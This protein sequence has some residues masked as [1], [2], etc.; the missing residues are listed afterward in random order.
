[1]T[2]AIADQR[3]TIRLPPH[4]VEIISKLTKVQESLLEEYGVEPTSKEISL[5][6]LEG[7]KTDP[8]FTLGIRAIQATALWPVSLETPAFSP[9]PSDAE[10]DSDEFRETLGDLLEDPLATIPLTSAAHELLR[11]QVEN[12]LHSLTSRERRVLQMRLGL[13]DGHS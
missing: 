5:G 13:E 4:L 6:K 7:N 2:R 8:S 11:E 10:C 9:G 3:R 12:V 1:V